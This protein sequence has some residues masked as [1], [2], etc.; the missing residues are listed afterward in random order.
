MRMGRL[1]ALC[2]MCM[3]ASVQP[4]PNIR[5]PTLQSGTEIDRLGRETGPT[6]RTWIKNGDDGMPFATTNNWLAPVS[7][8][9]GTSKFVETFLLPVAIAIVLGL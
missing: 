1:A 9:A 8:F 6:Y 4:L 3:F 5:E 7:A 2:R